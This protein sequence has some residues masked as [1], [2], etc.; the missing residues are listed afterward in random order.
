MVGT[1]DASQGLLLCGGTRAR[2]AAGP[3]TPPNDCGGGVACR[4]GWGWMPRS[5]TRGNFIQYRTRTRQD[6][7]P[8][9]MGAAD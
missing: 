7:A 8:N 2:T 5:H 4:K 6:I 1:P 3:S 9:A